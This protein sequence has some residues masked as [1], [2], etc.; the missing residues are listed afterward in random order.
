M[1]I[2]GAYKRMRVYKE[3]YPLLSRDHVHQ[4]EW[5]SFE[6]LVAILPIIRKGGDKE[7]WYQKAKNLIFKDLREE[8]HTV[9]GPLNNKVCKH[10]Q[11]SLFKKC[12]DCGA[13]IP[14]EGECEHGE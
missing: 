13:W 6:R 3:F 8:I 11:T 10:E 1:S 4:D 7:E 5:P 12:E 9:A 2:S 14:V